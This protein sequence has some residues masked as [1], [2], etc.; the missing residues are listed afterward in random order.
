M[1]AD[2]FSCFE[3][4]SD[5]DH[6]DEWYSPPTCGYTITPDTCKFKNYCYPSP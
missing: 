4:A 3:P 2:R 1:L 5:F 6:L